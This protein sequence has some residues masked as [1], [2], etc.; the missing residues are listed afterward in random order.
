MAYAQEAL[1]V[2]QHNEEK[3]KEREKIELEEE[4]MRQQVKTNEKFVKENGAM[5][6]AGL[7]GAGL[8]DQFELEPVVKAENKVN[9]GFNAK[10][11]NKFSNSQKTPTTLKNAKEN[12]ITVAAGGA[13]RAECA[14]ANPG[15]NMKEYGIPEITGWKGCA[16]EISQCEHSKMIQDLCPGTCCICHVA[17]AEVTEPVTEVHQKVT[18]RIEEDGTI[19]ETVS[20]VTTTSQGGTGEEIEAGQAA[21]RQDIEVT[22][23]VYTGLPNTDNAPSG[24]KATQ[25]VTQVD[26]DMNR[27]WSTEVHIDENSNIA[28]A[29]ERV[30]VYN[31]WKFVDSITADDRLLINSKFCIFCCCCCSCC[32]CCFCLLSFLC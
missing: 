19:V 11:A 22:S 14:C 31:R 15:D 3:V 26:N 12:A 20:Q 17:S 21:A 8:A 18:T 1:A 6:G 7:I 23:D 9:G 30:T 13:E 10:G 2:N 32:C 5:F 4:K 27:L 24:V 29:P 16:D 28:A 25:K